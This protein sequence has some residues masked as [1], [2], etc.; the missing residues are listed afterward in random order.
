MRLTVHADYTLRVLMYLALK[1][2][3]GAGATISEI[4]SAYGISRAHLMKIVNELATSGYVQTTRGRGGGARL[5]KRPAEISIGAVVR[6]A[7][8]DFSVVSCHEVPQS[9]NCAIQPACGLKYGMRRAMDAFL[10]ELDRMTLADAIIAPGV[11]ATLLHIDSPEAQ[12]VKVPVAALRRRRA[13][14]QA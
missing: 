1:A 4:A 2:Q 7:E 6:M 12:E 11:A 8:K 9:T 10:M 14:R 3:T 5:A 13:A